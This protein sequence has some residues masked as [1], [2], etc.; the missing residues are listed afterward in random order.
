[1]FVF[2]WKE[3]SYFAG[4]KFLEWA[5][6]SFQLGYI[7]LS[8]NIRCIYTDNNYMHICHRQIHKWSFKL[9]FGCLGLYKTWYFTYLS[10]S[11][12]PGFP[13]LRN[14]N[15]IGT[16]MKLQ[17]ITLIP[18]CRMQIWAKKWEFKG[19]QFWSVPW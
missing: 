18:F 15:F 16:I 14:K 13:V 4:R 10:Y 12:Y 11:K 8:L 5:R 9:L 19:W 17:N 2:S 6:S 7:F 3:T 1:M